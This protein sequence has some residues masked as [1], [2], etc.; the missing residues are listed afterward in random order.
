MQVRVATATMMILMAIF[1]PFA[2][3][4]KLMKSLMLF[5]AAAMAFTSCQNEEFNE[6]I[7]AN[8]TFTVNFVTDAPES[9]TS[10]SIEGGAANFA[11]GENE[12][13]QFI[14]NTPGQTALTLGTGVT[15]TN[16]AGK[17]EISATFTGD[18]ATSYNFTAVYP[19]A[20]W[21]DGT[22]VDKSNFNSAKLHFRDIQ[23]LVAGN[24]DPNADLL[25]SK[26]I[27]GTPAEVSAEAQSLQF[28][29]LVAIAEMNLKLLQVAEGEK[30]TGVKFAVS[31]G[32]LAGRSY[33]DL[34]TGEV[35][36]YGY[37]GKT[38]TITLTNTDGIEANAESVK[39]YFT[40]IPSTIKAGVTY[41]VTVTTDKAVYTQSA[42][43]SKDLTF[44]AGK[45][46]AFGV[47][48]ED[49]GVESNKS[50]AGDYIIVAKRAS[51]NFF[52]MTPD[53]GTASTKRF[54]AVDTGTTETAAIEMNEN[55]KWTVK[56]SD[57]AYTIASPAGTEITWTSGNSAN[58]AA[59]GKNMI[60]EKVNNANYYTISLADDATRKL[61]LNNTSGN[62]YFAF[63][64]G[65]QMHN[66]YL[67]PFVV[68]E[69]YEQYLSFGEI[70]E[71]TITE[72]DDFT[73][74]ELTGVETDVVSYTSSNTAVATVDASTGA[75]TIVG[76]GTTTITARAEGDDDFKPATASYTLTVNSATPDVIK[77]ITIAE[78]L[79]KADATTTYQLTGEITGTY[80]TYYGNF[81]LQDAT[82]KLQ[83]YGIY[84]ANGDKCYESLGLA[85]GDIITLQGVYGTY[86]S[87][88]QIKNATYISHTVTA[89]VTVNPESLIF[90]ADGGDKT[91]TIATR[92]EGN[93]TISEEADWLSYTI[94]GTTMTVT[95]T[96]NGG[97][98][99][100]ATITLTYA[101]KTA[102]IAV[103]QEEFSIVEGPTTSKITFADLYKADT[104]VDG[105]SIAIDSNIS[106]V[107][108]KA[109]SSTAPQYYT[110][111]KAVRMYQNGATLTV[112]AANGK[113]ITGVKLTYASS[114]NYLKA[115]TGTLSNTTTLGTW[116]GSASEILFTCYGTNKSQR[117]YVTAIEVTYE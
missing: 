54:Q 13:F 116:T 99:R 64:T 79:N 1:N 30:I 111:G 22:E 76:T 41:T 69:R 57:N 98:A 10:V 58:L 5:A 60:I 2:V 12:K 34:A 37:F 51:G 67:I 26:K 73:A 86:N 101:D 8:E 49:A 104:V 65:T 53:V 52:Y 89:N 55:Y 18:A 72:G 27:T 96:E 95:A 66:I 106:I 4:K 88:P 9:R 97:E 110:N 24:F 14:Q 94:N 112:T 3:M 20:A 92:G 102:T 32:T 84:D 74:P 61:G 16:N 11:W 78:F 77:E 59:T 35:V 50:L 21:V 107:F 7:E 85:D 19:A 113:T 117:A 47:N 38:G 31:D 25:V 6:G 62:N 81:Y 29:R 103:S 15:F 71:F 46:K 115:N 44:E 114:M 80:N 75:V 68:D 40:C 28:T 42:Q 70:T 56:E 90:A 105:T 100:N 91:V 45:V 82:G 108:A 48:M 39:V 43:L 93:L 83:I 109:K 23:N 63:Y 87:S 17:G 33:V 36:E